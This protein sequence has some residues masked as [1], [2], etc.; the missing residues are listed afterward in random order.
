MSDATDVL[1]IGA[2][3]A[4]GVAALHLASHGVSVTCLEQGGWSSASEYRGSERDWELTS[5][6]QWSANPNVRA[7][8]CDYAVDVSD[9]DMSVGM[10]NGVGGGTVLYNAVWPRLLPADFKTR[11]LEGVGDDWPLDYDDLRPFYEMTDRQFGVSGLGG[12]PFY[13]DSVDPPLPPLPI[14]AGGL[15]V[16]RAHARLGWNWW[17]DTNA[18]LSAPL[19][20]RHPCVQRGTCTQG[21]GEGA[22][23]TTDVTHWPQAVRLGAN[24]ITGA[25]VTRIRLDN[26]GLATGADWVDQRGGAHFQ[27]ASTILLAANGIGTARLLLASACELFPDGLANSSGLV[28]KRLMLHPFVNITGI[29]DESLRSWQGHNG[30]AI[31][32][33]EFYKSDESRGFVRGSKWSLHPTGGPLRIAAPHNGEGVW[34][35][36]HHRHVRERLGRSLTWVALCEDL[37]SDTNRVEL[38]TTLDDAGLAIPKITYKFDDNVTTMMAWQAARA[39]ESFLTAGALKVESRVSAY[40]AHLLGTARMGND[41]STSVVDRWGM[42]HDIPN[43]GVIDGSVFVT[44]GAVNPTSTIAAL[45]LRASQHLLERRGRVRRLRDDEGQQQPGGPRLQSANPTAIRIRK[46]V[47]AEREK[48]VRLAD[49][50]IPGVT[51]DLR[52]SALELGGDRLDEVLA[53]RPDLG[54]T[55][56]KILALD[57]SDPQ[58]RVADI[59]GQGDDEFGVLT[60][61]IAGAYYLDP[62]V[63]EAIGYPGQ[64]S[65]PVTI[66]SFPEYVAEGLLDHMLL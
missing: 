9:S 21:C 40:N 29:F 25:R 65:T 66:D 32:S 24:L 34:G 30:S 28:G 11:T 6:K 63:R 48:F 59:H 35:T 38:S 39:E 14:G 31:G 49:V 20:G 5:R 45:A 27:P 43:L 46:L 33:W 19:H 60:L 54:A 61:V 52:P 26:R 22:K 13:P 23:S 62:R 10:Y 64:E 47:L 8:E 44:A 4:G 42:T 37:P 2:G 36:E 51:E 12:N 16:A 53:A 15:L 18:I 56:H 17:P 50:L 3:A 7:R 55:L 57:F 41:P 58:Q 1:I